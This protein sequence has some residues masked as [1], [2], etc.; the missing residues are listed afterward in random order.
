MEVSSQV[1]QGWLRKIPSRIA[2]VAIGII[3]NVALWI[4]VVLTFP[5]STPAAVLHYTVGIGIDFIGPGKT[6]L[7]LPMV[8]S[9]LL[10]FNVIIAYGVNKASRRAA[11]IFITAIPVIQL[12]LLMVYMTLWNLNS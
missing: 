1:V 8:G 9:F 12:L 11:W 5:Q 4:L 2:I 6:I 3:L 10:L 7:R